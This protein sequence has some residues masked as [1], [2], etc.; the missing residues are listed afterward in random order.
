MSCSIDDH[1]IN[2]QNGLN[3]DIDWRVLSGLTPTNFTGPLGDH[4]SGTTGKYLYLEASGDCENQVAILTTACIDLSGTSAPALTFWYNMNGADMGSLHVDVVSEGMLYKDIM[5]P[6]E[7]DQGYD[8]LQVQVDLGEFAGQSITVRFRGM[9]GSGELSD[10]A[11][12][13]VMITEMT[14]MGEDFAASGFNI[15]PN[16]SKGLYQ[17]ESQY[18]QPGQVAIRVMDLSG[19]TIYE[20]RFEN[21]QAG[22]IQT[23]DIEEMENGIYFILLDTGDQQFKEKLL[24]Y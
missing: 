16:P 8:W 15:Y 13:D 17:L 14:G 11:I 20:R 24:K 7:G 2:L 19:R 5:D 23:I 6:V 10:M 9:T 3:D 4:T 21:L 1:Y 12:D 22:S 18:A